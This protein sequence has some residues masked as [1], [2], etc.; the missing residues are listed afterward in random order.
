MS[1]NTETALRRLARVAG[2]ADTYEAAG[3]VQ[4][5]PESTLRA[6]LTALGHPC[7]DEEEAT[8]SLR[9]LRRRP[10]IAPL[11]PVAVQWQGAPRGAHVTLS[12]PE[13]V[14]P[15]LTL[16]LEDGTHR[17]LAAIVWGG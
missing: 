15:Q 5:P 10:W 4:C 1:G 16:S 12:T 11:D 14:T 8:R 2:V 17:T 3:R 13:G 7:A 6:V 9:S